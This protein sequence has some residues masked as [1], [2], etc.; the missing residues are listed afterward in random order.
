MYKYK[1]LKDSKRGLCNSV[2]QPCNQRE[3]IDEFE[4]NDVKPRRINGNNC[5]RMFCV[6]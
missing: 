6:T 2:T 3:I 1:Y 5:A 4:E